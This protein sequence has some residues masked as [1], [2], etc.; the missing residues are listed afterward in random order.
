MSVL[1]TPDVQL[2]AVAR[3]LLVGVVGEG[4]GA[5]GAGASVEVP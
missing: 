2:V 1:V 4:W 5:C 3:L